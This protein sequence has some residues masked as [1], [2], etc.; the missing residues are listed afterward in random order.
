MNHILDTAKDLEKIGK[1][2]HKRFEKLISHANS[3]LDNVP[4]D[5]R[6]QYKSIMAQV[7]EA[8]KNQDVAKLTEL[9]NQLHGLI[10]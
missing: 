5:M 9:Q 2:L 4:E 6:E 3:Q 1:V 8:S 10:R 7:E